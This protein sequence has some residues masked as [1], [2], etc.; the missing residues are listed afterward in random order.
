MGNIFYE[1][2]D[3]AEETKTTTVDLK[4]TLQDITQ[5]SSLESV[6]NDVT[7][8]NIDFGDILT[9]ENIEEELKFVILKKNL[10]GG[11]SK[12]K[13][14]YLGFSYHTKG[15]NKFKRNC[16]SGCKKMIDNNRGRIIH[17]LKERKKNKDIIYY[18]CSSLCLINLSGKHLKQFKMMEWTEQP[19]KKV[20][21]DLYK[22]SE[23]V[24]D[25]E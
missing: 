6:S 14:I 4:A 19:V 17:K 25:E 24:S 13:C 18:H 2:C 22:I 23:K 5:T 20:V 3:E 7:S 16:C 9:Q 10:K 21:E 11:K 12:E 1:V 15:W 8:E